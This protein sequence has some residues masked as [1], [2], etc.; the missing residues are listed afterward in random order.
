VAGFTGAASAASNCA[1][2]TAASCQGR[3]LRLADAE[4]GEA[5]GSESARRANPAGKRE[6][7]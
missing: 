7:G 3:G 2:G 1:S 6:G 4:V 5:L